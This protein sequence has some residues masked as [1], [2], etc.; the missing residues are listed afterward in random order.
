MSELVASPKAFCWGRVFKHLFPLSRE[1]CNGCPADPEG[2]ITSD[3][4]YKLRLDP[5]IKLPA[6][7]PSPRLDRNMGRFS[8]MIISRPSDGP[9]SAEEVALIAEKSSRNS[10][11]VL[12]VPSRLENQILFDGILLNY[13]EFYFAVAHCP[14]LFSKGVVCIF[15]NDAVT[16]LI[17]YKN[18]GKLDAFGY[19]KILYCNENIIVSSDGK[20]IREYSEG[21]PVSIQ[22][23]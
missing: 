14:Y 11:G 16:N 21:Y 5:E 9:C 18:L 12:V 20:T 8:E 7:S 17:L 22:K 19:R 2:R 15:D 23:F 4:I 13:E 6:A 10:I 3:D 1:V